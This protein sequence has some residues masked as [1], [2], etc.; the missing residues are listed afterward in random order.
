MSRTIQILDAADA[1]VET[2]MITDALARDGVVVLRNMFGAPTLDEV[3]VAV[4]RWFAHP[5][6]AGVP[7]YAKIDAPK[8]LL[9]PTLLGGAVYDLLL[10]E[11]ILDAVEAYMKSECVLAEANLKY[12]APVDYLYFAAHADFAEGW[13]KKADSPPL[14]KE[15]MQF[16]VGVGGAIYLH[17]THE[18]AFS[19]ALGTHTMGAPFGQDLPGYPPAER[20]KILETWTRID[21]QRGDFVLFDDRGFHGPDQPSRVSR[22]VILVDYYRVETFGRKQV[23]P[24]PIWSTDIGRLNERQLRVLGAGAETWSTPHDYLLTRFRNNRAYRLATAIVENAYLLR[25]WKAKLKSRLRRNP[26]SMVE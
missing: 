26:G 11:R 22:T 7:G 15:Q 24:L 1:P 14:T 16:P 21:G 23:A 8:K 25:H 6:I 19:Y 3:D 2:G 18:G 9:S 4:T 5:A 20:A 13:R 17:E 12:D 10:D